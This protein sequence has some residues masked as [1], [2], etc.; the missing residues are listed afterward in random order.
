[1]IEPTGNLQHIFEQAVDVARKLNHE[2]VTIEHILFSIFCD[3]PSIEMLKE[4]GADIDYVK[5]N[6]ENYLRNN[7]KDIIK[8]N[9]Q[10]PKKTN[11]VER[12]LNRSFT[13]VLFSG[14]QRMETAD[15]I[16]SILSEKNSFGFYFLTKGGI[17]KEKF[18]KYFQNHIV[19]EQEEQQIVEPRNVAGLHRLIESLD[20]IALTSAY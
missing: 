8:E 1:M 19:V 11:S 7:L 10:K 3:D 9:V 13:Q 15:V 16:I 4:A 2:Y 17:T 18:V 5:S 14:R 12:V 6:L 20:S